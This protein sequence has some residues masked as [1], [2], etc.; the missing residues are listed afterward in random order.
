[1]ADHS[2]L[3]QLLARLHDPAIGGLNEYE[4]K[5]IV[6]E[7]GVQVPSGTL[8]A[9]SDVEN[10]DMDDLAGPFAVKFI[11]PQVSH[12]TEMGAVQINVPRD[13]VGATC[14]R[15]AAS[16]KL[17]GLRCDGFL[18]EQMAHPGLQ[19]M[20]LGGLHDPI[21]GPVVMVGLGG[22]FLEVLNDVSFRICPVDAV[23]VRAM[24]RELRGHQLLEGYRG[25]EP[26]DLEALV[27]AVL[28][29][30]GPE[31]LLMSAHPTPLEV[32]LNP[33]LASKQGAVAVDAQIL[34]P[35]VHRNAAYMERS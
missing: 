35:D 4:S 3:R 1:M 31:G 19:E 27:D 9:P 8:L 13:E 10:P 24:L 23:E 2:S 11:S 20:V 6:S 34:R 7:L 12:K 21:F 15:M 22:V 29:I 28:A 25:S 14:R 17:A 18:I 16:P 26:V 32:D 30:A 33:L 5:Q